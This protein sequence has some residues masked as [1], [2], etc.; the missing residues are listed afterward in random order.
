M[1]LDSANVD[2][3]I[4]GAVAF[5]PTTATAP[6]DADTPLPVEWRQVGYISDDGV[7]ETRDR[8]TDTIVAWQG[9]DVVRTVTTESSITVQFTAI[10]TNK[11][12]IA[13][14]YGAEVDALTGRVD[15]VPADSGGR[16]SLVVDYVDGTKFVRLY[17]PEAELTETGDLTMSGGD[18]AGYEVTITGY[19][20]STITNTAGKPVSAQ[21]FISALVT[22]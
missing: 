15:I 16:R 12:S 6:A 7:V 22:P 14:Y 13:L 10:E 5:A 19:P 8:S 20:S 4:T 18:P 21:K 9:S 2:V 1:A 3:A 17:L 11:D